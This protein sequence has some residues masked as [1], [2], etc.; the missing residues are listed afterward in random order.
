[1]KLFRV[2]KE[3]KSIAGLSQQEAYTVLPLKVMS[4]LTNKTKIVL[5]TFQ[6]KMAE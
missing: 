6:N 3:E 5:S 2:L 4:L 1:M